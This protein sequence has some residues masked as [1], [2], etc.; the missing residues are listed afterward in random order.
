LADALSNGTVTS[1]F[2]LRSHD[3]GIFASGGTA[4]IDRVVVQ[5]TAARAD[6]RFGDG[7]AVM[8]GLAPSTA[9]L[10]HVRVV[11]SARA[12]V[13][14]FGSPVSLGSSMLQCASW[15]LE[16][17]EHEGD[18]FAFEDRGGNRCGCPVADSECVS[19]SP[20]LEPPERAA[21]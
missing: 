3:I 13:S 9:A 11:E 7:I 10:D 4:T 1:T 20:G 18:P 19:V 21:P 8:S 14:S 17:E 5:G 16:G 12:A 6:G 15:D 2:V